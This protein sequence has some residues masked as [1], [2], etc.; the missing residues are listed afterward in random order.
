[1]IVD[2]DRIV[3]GTAEGVRTPSSWLARGP[4]AVALA[5]DPDGWWAVDGGTR[6]LRI[7]GESVEDVAAI[8][9]LPGRSLVTSDGGV[10]IGTADARIVRFSGGGLERDKPFDEAEGREAWYTPWGG[11]PDTRSLAAGVDGTIYANVHVGGILRGRSG[12]WEPTV[13]IDT[14]VHQV[15]AHPS[16]PGRVFAA[17]AVGLLESEDGGDTWRTSTEGLHATYSRAVGIAGEAILMSCSTG[18][19]GSRAAVYRRPLAGGEFTRC[20]N[21]LPD[22][23]DGNIDSHCLAA[24]GAV[25]V[26]GTSDG[27]VFGSEDSGSTWA[28]VAEDLPKIRCLSLAA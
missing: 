16:I 2:L 12:E 17:A 20:E 22:W 4:D 13:D 23:F 21:G 3:V 9:D 26:F 5:A 1:L 7:A 11:P 18:P 14:D 10:V 25:V 19:G 15:I 6:L 8:G 24:D 27:K 28:L